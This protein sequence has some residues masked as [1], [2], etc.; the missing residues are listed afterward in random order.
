MSTDLST[1]E[2]GNTETGLDCAQGFETLQRIAT[3]FAKSTLVPKDFQQNLPNCA[4]ALHMALRMKADPLMVMQ[5][6]YVVHGRPGWSSQFLIATFN[7]C[8]K[9]SALRYEWCGTP[10]QADYGCTAMAVEKASGETLRG[11]TITIDMA[12]KEGWATK[13]GSKWLTMP[14]QMLMYRAA[15]FFVRAYAPELAMGLPTAD[16]V[17]EI[18]D[19]PNHMMA[20]AIDAVPTTG[21]A[22]DRVAAALASRSTTVEA[23]D[24][25]GDAETLSEA[26]EVVMPAK[27]EPVKT[28][29]KWSGVVPTLKDI[30]DAMNLRRLNQIAE[31]LSAAFAAGALLPDVHET[32]SDALAARQNEFA[33]KAGA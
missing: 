23:D 7:Q 29:A 17:Q 26:P 8:G 1:M 14:Q 19:R 9:F 25:R 27:A 33:T 30:A 4:I 32:L 31:E 15:S 21:T 3:M 28:P 12:R 11:S 5:N 6:L 16:E 22:S 10:G 20:A 13:N 2:Q 18:D 24:S